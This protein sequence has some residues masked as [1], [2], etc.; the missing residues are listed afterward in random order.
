MDNNQNFNQM[1]QQPQGGAGL[2]IASMVL[3]ICSIV[4]CCLGYIAIVIAIV[5]LIL[6]IVSLKGQRAGRGM[7]IAG[8]ITSAIGLILLVVL[9]IVGFSV[10]DSVDSSYY[11]FNW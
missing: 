9:L 7:A 10:M 8:I 5:G 1:P 2:A 4:F 11:N 3:G 6:G